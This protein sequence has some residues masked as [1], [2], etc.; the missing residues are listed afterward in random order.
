MFKEVVKC[1]G[2]GRGSGGCEGLHGGVVFV[3]FT[4]GFAVR[5]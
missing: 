2:W 3:C 5:F 1:F 4:S